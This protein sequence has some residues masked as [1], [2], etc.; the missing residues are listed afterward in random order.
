[1]K[2]V[3][4]FNKDHWKT[5][6]KS[7][8]EQITLHEDCPLELKYAAAREM[9]FRRKRLAKNTLD[10]IWRSM[11]KTIELDFEKIRHKILQMRSEMTACGVTE[12]TARDFLDSRLSSLNRK[13]K[14]TSKG[15]A[16]KH[17]KRSR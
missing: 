17:V 5:A 11:R 10:S 8:L 2:H 12:S 14:N 4:C 7:Q 1:M 3:V 13:I 9:Q 15:V 16:R 6:S